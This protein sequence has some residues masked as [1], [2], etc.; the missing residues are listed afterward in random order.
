MTAELQGILQ[1]LWVADIAA[2]VVLLI[3]VAGHRH[4]R[5]F[6]AFSFYLLTNSALSTWGFF[7]YHRWGFTSPFF[8]WFA[9]GMQ[10]VI[11]CARA[12]AV[13]ELCKHLLARYRGIW[14]LAWRVMLG[15]AASVL[16]CCCVA[17][18]YQWKLALISTERGLELAIAVVIVAVFLFVRYYGVE[19]KPADRSLALGFC[20]YSCFIVLNNTI[21]EQL[22]DNY[23]A[24]W[25]FL[26]ML[27]YFGS[28]LL[29]TW[30]LR[31]PQAEPSPE[32]TLLPAGVY[33][34]VAPQINFRLRLL[35]ERLSQFWKTEATRN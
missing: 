2:G 33:Q 6:P 29:W 23:A 1:I 28:L 25:N 12:L 9:N 5:A 24:L 20:L 19:A 21:L 22:L 27:A 4:Y 11:I 17:A 8:W 34:A 32:E 3:L 35:N 18:R 7:A 16:I 14:G 10:A 15:S 26:G 30:A 31:Q 13:A